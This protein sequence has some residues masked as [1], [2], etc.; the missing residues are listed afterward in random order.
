MRCEFAR[1]VVPMA[2]SEYLSDTMKHC[3]CLAWCVSANGGLSQ[4]RGSDVGMRV[5]GGSRAGRAVC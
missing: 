2:L 3:R 1:R 5:D 4:V